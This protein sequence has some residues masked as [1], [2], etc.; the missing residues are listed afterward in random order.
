MQA[1]P[2]SQPL[3]AMLTHFSSRQHALFRAPVLLQKE[4]ETL[5][6]ARLSAWAGL[7]ENSDIPFLADPGPQAIRNKRNWTL[8]L[9]GVAWSE[10]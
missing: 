8:Q 10:A 5:N 2:P 3:K 1:T 7:L 6:A 4:P 9:A